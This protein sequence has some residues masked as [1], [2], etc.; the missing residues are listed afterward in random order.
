MGRWRAGVE[1]TENTNTTQRTDGIFDKAHK[2]FLR[3]RP[4]FQHEIN[5]GE[6]DVITC[7]GSE[8]VVHDAR[9]HADFDKMFLDNHLYDFDAVFC[10]KTDNDRVYAETVKPLVDAVVRDGIT[11]T[12]T[13]HPSAAY[14]PCSF[15]AMQRI[16]ISV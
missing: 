4:L 7:G 15:L 8:V 12:V 13:R 2:V 14:N 11:A 6:F 9:M 10:D 5:K 16:P 3:K 1:Q